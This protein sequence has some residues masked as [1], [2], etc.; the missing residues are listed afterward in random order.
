[1]T[2]KPED[3]GADMGLEALF[4]A[5]KSS[6]L[7]PPDDL[8]AAVLRDAAAMQPAPA[9]RT[10]AKAGRGTG[11]GDFL[12]AFGGW[13]GGL[14]LASCLIVGLSLGYTPPDILRNLASDMLDTAGISTGGGVYSPL[15]DMLAEG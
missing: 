4:A 13:Q 1:M 8:I 2:E 6:D 12:R 9:G 7:T 15:E 3:S 11:F 5:E 14:V 10:A